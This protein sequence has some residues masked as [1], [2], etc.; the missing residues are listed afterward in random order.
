M[1]KIIIFGTGDIY[2][3]TYNYLLGKDIKIM[4]LSDN[5]KAKWG[6]SIDNVSII[7]PTDIC[8]QEFDAIVICVGD[9]YYEEVYHQLCNDLRIPVEKI[10]HWTYWMRKELLDFYHSRELCDDNAIKVID[11]IEKN[12][13]LG[14][15]NYDFVEL[16]SRA[17]CHFDDSC[18]MYYG[19][20][21]G[22][23]LYLN[24]N[25]KT[26]RQAEHYIKYLN[27][28]QDEKSPHRYFDENFTFDGGIVLDAGAAEGNFTLEIIEKV[29]KAILVEADSDWN[30]AL[31]KTFEPWKEKIIII[32]KYLSDMDD[33]SHVSI[34]SLTKEHNIKFVKM[35]IEGAEVDALKGGNDFFNRVDC[36][37]MVVCAYHN[38]DDEVKIRNILQP[39]SFVMKNTKGYMV[40]VDNLRQEPRLVHG[41]L[42]AE[43]SN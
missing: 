21:Q 39:Y 41:I 26:K 5:D 17:E 40:F 33:S 7:P 23:R 13:K 15:F 43:I 3:K 9:I 34:N 8:N 38:N 27:I 42:R 10:R 28:E 20:Y 29:E 6:K 24:R 32:N 35:D 2:K 30:E 16:H 22:K 25:Y 18:G 11:N 31:L 1:E 12:D 14:A 19:L 37:K 36:L 4:N